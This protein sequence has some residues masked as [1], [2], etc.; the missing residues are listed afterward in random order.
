MLREVF[1]IVSIIVTEVAVP[2]SYVTVVRSDA[3]IEMMTGTVT[4]VGSVGGATVLFGADANMFMWAAT[5]AAL[6]S[7]PMPTRL[8]EVLALGWGA[9]SC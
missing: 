1:V 6:G 9:C 8:E 5:M 2:V 7:M 3:M 4:S